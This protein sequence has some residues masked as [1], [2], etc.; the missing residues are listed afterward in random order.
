MWMHCDQNAIIIILYCSR[1]RVGFTSCVI[2]LSHFV[3]S[4]KWLKYR[5]RP[6]LTNLQSDGYLWVRPTQQTGRSMPPVSA[7]FEPIL[8]T[9]HFDKRWKLAYFGHVIAWKV[10]SKS[11]FFI[12]FKVICDKLEGPQICHYRYCYT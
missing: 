4:C 6:L 11:V 9:W 8:M 5:S 7:A 1:E 3:T 2:D 12:Y 10:R